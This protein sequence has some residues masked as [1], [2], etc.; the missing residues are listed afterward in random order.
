MLSLID[1]G[2][3]IVNILQQA[4]KIGTTCRVISGLP[5]GPEANRDLTVESQYPMIGDEMENTDTLK[6]EIITLRERFSRFSEAACASARV[7]TS[8]PSFGR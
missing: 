2:V 1:F 4:S 8:I 3:N 7:L 5:E 6:A